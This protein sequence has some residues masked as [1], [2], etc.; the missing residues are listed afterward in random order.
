MA[1]E[2]FPC[3]W[4]GD[5]NQP[6]IKLELQEVLKVSLRTL[7]QISFKQLFLSKL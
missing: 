3:Y 5:D 6:G 1:E 4:N 7:S 2:Q